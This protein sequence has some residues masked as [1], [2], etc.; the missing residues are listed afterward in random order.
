MTITNL[1]KLAVYLH[2]IKYQLYPNKST[3]FRTDTHTNKE[4]KVTAHRKK[5]RMMGHC[6]EF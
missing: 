6:T 3:S 5:D 1:N 2:L 4:V